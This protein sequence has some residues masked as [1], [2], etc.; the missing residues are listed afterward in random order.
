M[1]EIATAEILEFVQRL[2]GRYCR[3]VPKVAT[4]R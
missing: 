2:G 1:S 4:A 3:M